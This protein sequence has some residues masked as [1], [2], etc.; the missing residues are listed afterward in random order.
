MTKNEQIK[1]QSPDVEQEIIKAVKDCGGKLDRVEKYQLVGKNTVCPI[2]RPESVPYVC[3]L[4]KHGKKWACN[5]RKTSTDELLWEPKKYSNSI[6]EAIKECLTGFKDD[7]TQLSPV[8]SKEVITKAKEL[9]KQLN[10]FVK[11]NHLKLAF[12]LEDDV[13]FLAPKDTRWKNGDSA[14]KGLT[15]ADGNLIGKMYNKTTLSK[16]GDIVSIHT[17]DASCDFD[18]ELF[19]RA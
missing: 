4:V 17:G 5:R 16:I 10:S 19:Y 15:K 13:I 18:D 1:I 7:I 11:E 2:F 9:Y 3:Q 6:A 12:D 8:P 14:P